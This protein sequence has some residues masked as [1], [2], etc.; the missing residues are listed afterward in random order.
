MS[1]TTASEA[2]NALRKVTQAAE[3]QILSIQSP[4]KGLVNSVASLLLSSYQLLRAEKE[5]A[6]ILCVPAKGK[7]H[8]VLS[9][10]VAAKAEEQQ[11]PG[12]DRLKQLSG[13]VSNFQ[14]K[15][16]VIAVAEIDNIIW[17]I[18]K[19]KKIARQEPRP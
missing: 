3:A 14:N 5:L 8:R 15:P 16:E 7:Y 1:N 2:E 11:I 9:A 13:W 12:V 19:I 18:Y 17:G 4:E 10:E 6:R